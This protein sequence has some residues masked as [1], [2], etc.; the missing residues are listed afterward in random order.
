MLA[1]GSELCK[2]FWSLV[3]YYI[4]IHVLSI[5]KSITGKCLICDC[6]IYLLHV[7]THRDDVSELYPISKIEQEVRGEKDIYGPGSLQDTYYQ[8]S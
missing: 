6:C 1:N 8:V 4:I 7:Y 2:L 5:A 3:Y